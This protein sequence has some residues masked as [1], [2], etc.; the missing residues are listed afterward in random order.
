MKCSER[1]SD[2]GCATEKPAHGR[3]RLAL[4]GLIQTSTIYLFSERRRGYREAGSQK[5]ALTG[6]D[7]E[8]L[9]F[10]QFDPRLQS[11]LQK[12]FGSPQTQSV[13]FIFIFYQQIVFMRLLVLKSH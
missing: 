4:Y 2:G 1:V 10:L 6:I 7:N 11:V 13:N 3:L 12:S 5:A 9:T 8:H